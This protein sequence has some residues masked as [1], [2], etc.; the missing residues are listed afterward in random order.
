MKV[1]VK[2]GDKIIAK[3]KELGVDANKAIEVAL[4]Q[5]AEIIRAEAA[6]KAPKRT[7]K[8]AGSMAVSEAKNNSIDIGPSKE[9]FYGMFLE[10]GTKKMRARPFLRPSLDEKKYDVK[11][12]FRQILKGFIR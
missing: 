12:K 11:R 2:G 10:L 8:L 9:A 3:L 6:R 7:G 4:K 1:T 5:S